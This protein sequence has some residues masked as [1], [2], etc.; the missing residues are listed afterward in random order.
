MTESIKTV[1][2]ALFQATDRNKLFSALSK[3]IDEILL[4]EK[5]KWPEKFSEIT[6]SIA[7]YL[8]Q[9]LQKEKDSGASFFVSDPA[10]ATLAYIVESLEYRAAEDPEWALSKLVH[11]KQQIENNDDSQISS[12]MTQISQ[13][14]RCVEERHR[15]F[16]TSNKLWVVAIPY[17]D[18][19]CIA[20][21]VDDDDVFIMYLR[22]GEADATVTSMAI[23]CC[24]LATVLDD[25]LP[26]EALTLLENT[27]EPTI[28]QSREEDQYG[29]FLDAIA[30]G[31][32]HGSPYESCSTVP[33]QQAAQWMAFADRMIS[34]RNSSK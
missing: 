31:L 20:E 17:V 1:L 33:D 3:L 25:D 10:F 19:D 34:Q 18:I 9:K 16:S 14:L 30:A 7:S 15:M 8:D 27:C 32:V 23:E 21:C 13:I 5:T 22:A 4:S 12:A 6:I 24:A 2:N 11:Y 26:P 29:S 28:R